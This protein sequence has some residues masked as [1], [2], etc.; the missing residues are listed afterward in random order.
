MGFVVVHHIPKCKGDEELLS[1]ED[2]TSIII[3]L[4]YN[5]GMLSTVDSKLMT[6]LYCTANNVFMLSTEDS[7]DYAI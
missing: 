4:Q 7:V 2:S 5:V 1:T 6:A 3:I